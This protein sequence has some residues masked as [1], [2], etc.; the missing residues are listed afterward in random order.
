VVDRHTYRIRLK[1]KYPQFLYWL[2]MPFFA[3]VPWEADLFHAQ[4][5]HGERNLTLDWYPIGTGPYML[6]ENDPN[7]RMVL[8]RNPNFR[9]E[10]LSV[11]R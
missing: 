9:E 10:D 5:G 4:P 2:A 1:G 7:A 8:A 6:S 11:R 3:P